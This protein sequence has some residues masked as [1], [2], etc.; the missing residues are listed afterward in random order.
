MMEQCEAIL[1]VT[2]KGQKVMEEAGDVKDECR[3]YEEKL[4]MLMH[5]RSEAV[6][7]MRLKVEHNRGLCKAL[8]RVDSSTAIL[9]H[10][11]KLV[12]EDVMEGY[13]RELQRM[14]S[15]MQKLRNATSVQETD[16]IYP[17]SVCAQL[18]FGSC[19]TFTSSEWTISLFNQQIGERM[20]SEN[21][22]S[23]G[24]RF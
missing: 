20:I 22:N 14:E 11:T 3:R 12:Q 13:A 6:N 24:I 21:R 15:I 1:K 8:V 10:N 23:T 19:G 9:T 17:R 4:K 7:Q 2:G 5:D 18:Y 16:D